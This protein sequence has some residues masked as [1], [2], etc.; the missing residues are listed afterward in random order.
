MKLSFAIPTYNRAALLKETIENIAGQ[1]GDNK[2]VDIVISD[3]ASTDNTNDVIKELQIKYPYIKYFRNETNLGMDR[4][5]DNAVI[6]ATGEYVWLFGD[7]DLL[8]EGALHKV[9]GIFNKYDNLALVYVN[10][11][12][13]PYLTKDKLT[14]NIDDFLVT[15]Q[16][17]ITFLSSLVVKKDLWQSVEKTNF[18]GTQFVQ[19]YTVLSFLPG[20]QAFC[21]ADKYVTVQPTNEIEDHWT[22]GDKF[23]TWFYINIPKTLQYFKNDNRFSKHILERIIRYHLKSLPRTILQQKI[24]KQFNIS[25]LA[26]LKPL[27]T[28]YPLDWGIILLATLIPAGV[29]KILQKLWKLRKMVQS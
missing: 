15:V 11:I 5:F 10:W 27:Y 17:G 7:D 28:H 20:H 16:T 19:V 13:N 29:A 14:S 18:I 1:I 6:K 8:R 21:I 9:L 23:I 3:N 25:M 12:D 4:N 2:D 24:K 22:M 26:E